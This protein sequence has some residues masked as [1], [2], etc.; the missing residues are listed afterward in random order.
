MESATIYDVQEGRS[1]VCQSAGPEAWTATVKPH[2]TAW[3]KNIR[4]EF[5]AADSHCHSVRLAI[6]FL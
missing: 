1:T 6:S 3:V 4:S 2:H 5:T